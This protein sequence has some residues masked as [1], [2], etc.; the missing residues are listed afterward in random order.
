MFKKRGDA[1]MWEGAT[2]VSLV[3]LEI[4]G[5]QGRKGEGNAWR[6]NRLP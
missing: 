4:R 2:F 5:G 1:G 6:S 3:E